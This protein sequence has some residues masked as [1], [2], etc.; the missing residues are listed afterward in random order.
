MSDIDDA[1]A[2][3]VLGADPLHA[4]PI[5]DLRIRKAMRR[6]GAASPSPASGPRPSTAAPPRPYVYAPGEA[7]AAIEQIARRLRRTAPVS[8]TSCAASR[9]VIVWG[10]RLAVDPETRRGTL[11]ERGRRA[12]GAGLLE[13]PEATN[14]RGLREVGLP[15]RR[16]ARASRGAPGRD[17][18]GIRDGLDGGRARPR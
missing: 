14:A 16:R 7:A 10:E 17:A 18:A 1:E 4:A 6:H 11:L 8:P 15:P 12:R 3:L 2:I 5:L 9:T 13:V